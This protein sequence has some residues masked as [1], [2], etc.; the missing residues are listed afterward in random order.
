MRSHDR[1]GK[2]MSLMLPEMTQYTGMSTEPGEYQTHV[3]EHV[4]AD[5]YM[6]NSTKVER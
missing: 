6:I 4:S 2:T 1:S 3:F 5:Q